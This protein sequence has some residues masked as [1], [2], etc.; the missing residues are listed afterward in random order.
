[1][2]AANLP[3]RLAC[4]PGTSAFLPQTPYRE[5]GRP[6]L[7]PSFYSAAPYS[8]AIDWVAGLL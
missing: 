6:V 5:C 8:A 1:M 3:S 2:P 4:V 7:A